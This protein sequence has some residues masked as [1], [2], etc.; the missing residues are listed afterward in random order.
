M[1]GFLFGISTGAWLT[2][3]AMQ[4]FLLNNV[5]LGVFDL[6]VAVVMAVAGIVL[7]GLFN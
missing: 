3:S 7:T 2:L 5:F 6:A 1:A 4:F